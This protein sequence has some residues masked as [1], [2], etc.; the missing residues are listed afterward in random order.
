MKSVHMNVVSRT[1][2]LRCQIITE[3]PATATTITALLP[4]FC[5]L[6]NIWQHN[7]AVGNYR[8]YCKDDARQY[9]L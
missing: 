3:H 4:H 7:A 8:Y 6:K 2:P 9:S 1:P 5:S